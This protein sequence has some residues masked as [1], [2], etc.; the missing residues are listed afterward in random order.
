MHGSGL[1]ECSL[2]TRFKAKQNNR[3]QTQV[4]GQKQVSCDVFLCNR[5]VP[6]VCLELVEC[7]CFWLH[8]N[9]VCLFLATAHFVIFR[10]SLQKD[11]S[12]I[13]HIT[14]C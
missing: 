5:S 10:H 6:C 13:G 14:A 7:T 11:D 12:V 2:K 8:T 3:R 4:I 1:G 9:R